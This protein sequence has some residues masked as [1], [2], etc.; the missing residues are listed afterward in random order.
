[1]RPK[2][3]F[4]QSLDKVFDKIIDYYAPYFDGN[5]EAQNHLYCKIKYPAKFQT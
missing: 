5:Y 4:R 2:I 3:T 1:M